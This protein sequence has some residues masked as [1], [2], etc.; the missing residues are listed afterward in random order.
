MLER[1]P[2]SSHL[3]EIG[4]RPKCII[5]E[6][7]SIQISIIIPPNAVSFEIIEDF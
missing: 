1:N 7:P 2:I 4:L 3:F 6:F 5:S